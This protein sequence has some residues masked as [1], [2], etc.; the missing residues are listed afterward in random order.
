M[1]C[2]EAYTSID[3]IENEALV[4]IGFDYDSGME[5]E[6]CTILAFFGLK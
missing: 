4:A 1:I 3:Q 2:C 6:F 5:S